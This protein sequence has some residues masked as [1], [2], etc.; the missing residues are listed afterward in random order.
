MLCLLLDLEL[1]GALTI[2]LFRIPG[3]Q[4]GD[5]KVSPRFNGA[6]TYVELHHAQLFQ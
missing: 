3:A 1:K 5:S 6:K 4:V 2:G